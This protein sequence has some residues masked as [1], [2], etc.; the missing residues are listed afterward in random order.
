MYK[1]FRHLETKCI[2]VVCD[3]LQPHPKGAKIE[4]S[5]NDGYDGSYAGN[6]QDIHNQPGFAFS[7]NGPVKRT[8][9]TNVVVCRYCWFSDRNIY[10]KVLLFRFYFPPTVLVP[11]Y[12]PFSVLCPD[13]R[14][15]SQVCLSFWSQRM[16]IKSS[17]GRTS[18][19][20][21]ASTSTVTAVCLCGLR[22]WRWTVRTRRTLTGSKRKPLRSVPNGHKLGFLRRGRPYP[23]IE[24]NYKMFL[25]CKVAPAENAT[26]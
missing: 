8:V 13:P 14:G 4:V 21:T 2:F 17:R 6:P 7:R 9:V 24:F 16:A 26:L 3:L 12:C 5:I 18:A 15:R 19:D 11:T 25:Q 22:R 23:L 10:L 1:L 20:T